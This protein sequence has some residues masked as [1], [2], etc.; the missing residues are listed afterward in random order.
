MVEAEEMAFEPADAEHLLLA[1]ARDEAG[2]AGQILLAFGANYTVVRKVLKT[3]L[4][5]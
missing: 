5:V 2:V 1:L 3:L 4:V